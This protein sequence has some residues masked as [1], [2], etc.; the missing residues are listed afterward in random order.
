MHD[1]DDELL[2]RVAAAVSLSH[3]RIRQTLERLRAS[4]DSL[5][6]GAGVVARSLAAVTSSA[7]SLARQRAVP[8]PPSA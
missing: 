3:A 4:Q 2:P 6:R 7:R 8:R 1:C 5:Q